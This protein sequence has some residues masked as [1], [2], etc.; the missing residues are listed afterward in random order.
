MITEIPVT[1][2]FRGANSDDAFIDF[3]DVAQ[4]LLGFQRSLALTTHLVLNGEVITQAPALKGARIFVAPPEAGSW[5]IPAYIVVGLTGIYQLGTAPK[6]SPIGHMVYSLYDYVIS[7]SLGVHVDYNRTLGQIYEEAQR[8]KL[9]I[10]P[11]TESQADSLIEKCSTAIREMHRPITAMGTAK[12]A[13]VAMI[14][15]TQPIPLSS[16]LSMHTYEFMSETRQSID[17][18]RII[19]RVSSYNSNTYK[20]RVY[21][22]QIGRPV[23]FELD[24]KGRSGAAVQSITTSL[25]LN[26]NGR[27]DQPG[28][29][30]VMTVFRRESKAGHLKSF[31]AL[32]VDKMRNS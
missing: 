6:D 26:A 21:V 24:P 25:H 16:K 11:V 23:N 30:I 27:G 19:G 13:S 1:L 20:G 29:L 31:L 14:L 10:K 9:K 5:K 12:T 15:D 8:N 28:A 17:V 22:P 7:E 3:Y 2:S 4:A 18:E 32:H